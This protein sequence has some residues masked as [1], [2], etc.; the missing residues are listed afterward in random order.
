MCSQC[1]SSVLT[2]GGASPQVLV[3]CPWRVP[4]DKQG[5][6]LVDVRSMQATE[7]AGHELP[8]LPKPPKAS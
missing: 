8:A 3:T 4:I 7:R 1:R 2:T 6:P 5:F